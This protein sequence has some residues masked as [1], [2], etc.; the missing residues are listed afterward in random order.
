MVNRGGCG[1]IG[2]MRLPMKIY[3]VADV[4]LLVLVAYFALAF[5]GVVPRPTRAASGGPG[6]AA[7]AVAA[8]VAALQVPGLAVMFRP[9]NRRR[10]WLW[11]VAALPPILFFL[12]DIAQLITFVSRRGST[13]VFLLALLTLAGMVAL[14]ITAAVSFM[15]VRAGFDTR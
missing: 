3:V 10:A 7:V 4:V 9:S 8:V 5:A 13:G 14:A 12:P 2:H 15:Q 11:L 6:A 1:Q